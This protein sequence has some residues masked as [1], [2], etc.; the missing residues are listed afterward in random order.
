[1]I[2]EINWSLN[3]IRHILIILCF[4]P[5]LIVFILFQK[6]Y[7]ATTDENDSGTGASIRGSKWHTKFM[8]SA[9]L[10]AGMIFS[11]SPIMTL[12]LKNK[13][14][15][16][17]KNGEYDTFTGIAAHYTPDT[18]DFINTETDK[19]ISF[20]FSH[21]RDARKIL[22]KEIKDNEKYTVY[23]TYS[24]KNET[25]IYFPDTILRIDRVQE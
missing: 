14:I 25:G 6:K 18:V 9:L 3:D 21:S 4:I 23:F 15:N 19:S 8:I 22:V 12:Y 13:S 2:Y 7:D 10:V 5:L 16:C 17:Y 11:L 20:E 24:I 1:M